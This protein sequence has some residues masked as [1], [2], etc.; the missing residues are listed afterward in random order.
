[1]PEE[2]HDVLA[3]HLHQYCLGLVLPLTNARYM[4]MLKPGLRSEYQSMSLAQYLAKH[5]DMAII[6]VT[7]SHVTGRVIDIR[8]AVAAAY[9]NT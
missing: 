9:V 2:P 6:A 3:C 7:I 8:P 4:T 1:M 5:L